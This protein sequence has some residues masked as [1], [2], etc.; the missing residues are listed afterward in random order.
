MKKKST[1]RK[2]TKSTAE[3]RTF[4]EQEVEVGEIPYGDGAK[5]VFT[6][7]VKEDKKF[8]TMSRWYKSK[9]DSVW[10]LSKKGTILSLD[11]LPSILEM[12]TKAIEQAK[13]IDPK[14]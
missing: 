14:K 2:T 6:I 5:H 8:I 7:C 12:Y 10:G 13:T 3:T 1:S 4:W 11:Q 9:K